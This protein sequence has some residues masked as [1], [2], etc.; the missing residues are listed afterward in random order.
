M[1][2]RVLRYK[3][4]YHRSAGKPT[5]TFHDVG[6]L[7]DGTLHNPNGYPADEVRAAVLAANERRAARRSEAAKKATKT[8][9]KR[10]EKK[11]YFVADRLLANQPVGPRTTCAICGRGLHD[12]PSIARGIGSECWQGVLAGITRRNTEAAA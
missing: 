1:T 8:R 7:A 2:T 3:W 6:I 4:V 5:E 9:I 10:Q 11:T 12:P